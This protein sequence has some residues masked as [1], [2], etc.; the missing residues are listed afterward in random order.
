MMDPGLELQT[1]GDPS[2]PEDVATSPKVWRHIF[3]AIEQPLFLHDAQ[4]RLLLVNRAY[5]DAAAVTAAQALGK[6]YWE[7]FPPGSGPLPGCKGTVEG[8]SSERSHDEV[9]V[10]AKFF[11]SS[12]SVVRDAD[13][14]M[15][16]SMHILEDITERKQAQDALR[17]NA[18]KHRL[19]FENSPYAQMTLAPPSWQFTDAN[20]ATVQLFGAVS[21]TQFTGL[22][23]WDLSPR[24]QPD[25]RLSSEK[26]QEMISAAM[27]E[28]SHFFEWEHQRLD[29]QPFAADVLLTR[30]QV[31][32]HVFLQATVRDISERKRLESEL[33]RQAHIDMLTGLNN[34]H[35]FFELAEQELARAK[36]YGTSLVALMIDLDHFKLVNDRFGHQVGDLVLQKFSQVCVKTLRSV[37]IL[38]RIGGEEFAVLMPQTNSAR[39]QEVAER[40]R[41]AVASATVALPQDAAVHFTISVG[42]AALLMADTN[43]EDLLKRADR[44]LYAAKNG[45]RNRVC[46]DESLNSSA[47]RDA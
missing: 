16:Y 31:N 24:L 10:N 14:K 13:G 18:A 40:L 28:G 5:C 2:R 1:Q 8:R 32:S 17:L 22:G 9:C 38:G 19:L 26:A 45:G 42:A 23:P 11:S 7:V 20:H 41:Q 4:F 44:Q 35:Y 43:V 12:G 47:D 3:D 33:K 6:P 46:W 15:L 37:D 25:G 27:R 39:A 36:R 29:G 34:R 30:V 21:V